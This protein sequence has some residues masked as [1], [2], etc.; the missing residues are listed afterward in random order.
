VR[1][2]AGVA[3]SRVSPDRLKQAVAEY[4]EWE[5]FAFWVRSVVAAERRIPAA[6]ASRLEEKCPGILDSIPA[7]SGDGSQ[8]WLH[9][10]R[11]IEDQIFGAA[12]GEGWL[13]AVRFFARGSLR[14]ERTADYRAHCELRW[15][16]QRPAAYPDFEEWRRA[17][18]SYTEAQ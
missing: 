1:R 10:I 5:A 18:D 14:A 4:I 15:S 12:K 9:L 17:A 11:W 7:S 13:E 16:R 8:L 3:A 2:R 6:V